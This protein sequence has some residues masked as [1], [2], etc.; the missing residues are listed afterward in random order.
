MIVAAT[1]IEVPAV[2]STVG[3]IEVWTSEIEVVAMR[4]AGIDA[5]VPV[6]CIPV[7]RTV[8]IGGGTESIPLPGVE[9]IV[10]VEVAALPVDTEHIVDSGHT[11]QVVEVDLV[12]SLILSVR[13][14][15][16]LRACS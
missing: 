8:E 9:N 6:A 14:R 1:T 11:H 7:E 4:I 15:A 5:E 3:G 10:Q 13:N 16:S 12:G 2:A